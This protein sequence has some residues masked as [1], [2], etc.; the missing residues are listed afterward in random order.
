M[1]LTHFIE[2]SFNGCVQ[3]RVGFISSRRDI[4]FDGLLMTD[5]ISMEALSGTVAA[6]AAATVDLAS[7]LLGADEPHPEGVHTALSLFRSH[8]LEHKRQVKYAEFLG[9][10]EGDSSDLHQMYKYASLEYLLSTQ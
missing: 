6:R 10:Y 1:S 5:D 3:F 4:G 9:E 7:L 8:I 2:Q